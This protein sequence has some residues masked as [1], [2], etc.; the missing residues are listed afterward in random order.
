MD[1]QNVSRGNINSE[2]WYFKGL[3]NA[4]RNY[5][6]ATLSY[7]GS[8]IKLVTDDGNQV[9]QAQLKDVGFSSFGREGFFRIDGHRFQVNFM[10]PSLYAGLRARNI[11]TAS[12]QE[13]F[14]LNIAPWLRLFKAEGGITSNVSS[15]KIAYA[16]VIMFAVIIVGIIVYVLLTPSKTP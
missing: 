12:S 4:K 10:D 1:D 8:V 11:Q 13:K 9:F 16:F 5:H 3:L 6:H 2:V 15:K 14:N 7:D